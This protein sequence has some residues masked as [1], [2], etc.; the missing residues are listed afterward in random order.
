MCMVCTQLPNPLRA[1]V[2]PA[3]VSEHA[4]RGNDRATQSS[5]A[6]SM[7]MHEVT[8]GREMKNHECMHA[9]RAPRNGA[10]EAA[11]AKPKRRP[12]VTSLRLVE[13]RYKLDVP[14]THLP[15]RALE[16]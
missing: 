2:Q 14:T 7:C 11:E 3:C 9:T 5:I 15:V 4:R 13:K 12:N 16:R 6:E 1:R 10:I 8:E